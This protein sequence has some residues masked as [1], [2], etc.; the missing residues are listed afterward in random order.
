MKTLVIQLEKMKCFRNLTICFHN[1]IK[2][3]V[4]VE[5]QLN[6]NKKKTTAKQNKTCDPKLFNIIVVCSN[7]PLIC[8]SEM[9]SIVSQNRLLLI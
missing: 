8:L 5:T 7:G 9:D 4:W 2:Y 6:K 1:K 3:V